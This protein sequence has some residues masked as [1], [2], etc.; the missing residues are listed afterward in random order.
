[1]GGELYDKLNLDNVLSRGFA[2]SASMLPEAVCR[3]K[4]GLDTVN[5]GRNWTHIF[6]VVGRAYP[7]IPAKRSDVRNSVALDLHQPSVHHPGTVD[8][9]LLG[10][11]D[12]G[13]LLSVLRGVS[14]EIWSRHRRVRG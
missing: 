2:V 10:N 9:V 5:H 1:M 11:G 6:I 3:S 4:E 13:G 14:A 12:C 7:H 8:I